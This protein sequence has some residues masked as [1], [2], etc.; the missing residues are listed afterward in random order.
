MQAH[1]T[2]RT[3]WRIHIL[4]IIALILNG[5]FLQDIVDFLDIWMFFQIFHNGTQFSLQKQTSPDLSIIKQ[6][7]VGCTLWNLPALAECG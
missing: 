6:S 2:R 4:I 1:I 5:V 7:I 3:Y